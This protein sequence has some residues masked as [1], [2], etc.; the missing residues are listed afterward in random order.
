[1]DP[2]IQLQNNKG[3]RKKGK[4]GHLARSSTLSQDET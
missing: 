2:G 3:L 4:K 1:M